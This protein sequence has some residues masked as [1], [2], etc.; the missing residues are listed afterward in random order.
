M[1]TARMLC[2]AMITMAVEVVAVGCDSPT[3]SPPTGTKVRRQPPA[4]PFPPAPEALDADLK[5]KA[6]AVIDTAITSPDPVVRA[7]AIEA[8][9]GGHHPQ[10]AN[11]ALRGMNDSDSLVRFAGC[12]AAGGLKSRDAYDLALKL[13]YDP[14]PSVRIGARY[15]LHR[16]GDH[17]L[18]N[19]LLVATTDDR[20]YVRGDAV[21]V[22]GLLGEKSALPR[23]QKMV[24]DPEPAIRLQVIEAMWRLGDKSALEDLVA[25]TLSSKPDE[26]VIAVIALAQGGRG[27]VMPYIYEQLTNDF[28]EVQLAAARGSGMLGWDEGYGVATQYIVSPESRQRQ[29]AALAFAAI[30][31]SDSQ[32]LLAPTLLDPSPEVR[33]AGATAILQLRPPG[34]PPER[35][36]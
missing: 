2:F 5:L 20:K 11:L 35:Y 30:G 27:D 25:R 13:A 29:M 14:D 15:C 18:T 33:L 26:A 32:K 36:R 4:Y 8:A 3:K 16:L 19:E 23:L 6:V 28:P 7:N 24:V 17:R 22:L 12:M 9:Q 10:A 34:T 21:L 1:K 31:R